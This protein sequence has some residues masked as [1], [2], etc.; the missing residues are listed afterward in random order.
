ML[1]LGSSLMIQGCSTTRSTGTSDV[2]LIWQGITY[3]AKSDTPETVLQVRRA[4][5]KREAYCGN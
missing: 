3:S 5:A 1:A 2:C 4:N